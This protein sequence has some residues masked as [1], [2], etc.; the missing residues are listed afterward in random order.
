MSDKSLIKQQWLEKYPRAFPKADKTV[1]PVP[2]AIVVSRAGR[3]R[4]RCF[5][6]TKV[7]PPEMYEKS[8]RVMVT[9]GDLR[10]TA[11]QKKKNLSH[12]ILVGMSDRAATLIA[13]GALTDAAAREIVEEFRRVQIS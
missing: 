3:D 7:L 12:L 5:I 10:P 11:S 6:I 13:D 9:D 8:L 1:A 2:G 4:Y